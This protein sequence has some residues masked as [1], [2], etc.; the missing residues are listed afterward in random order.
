MIITRM[1]KAPKVFIIILN[2]NGLD[3]VEQCLGG[4]FQISYSN[5]EVVVVDNNSQDGSFELAKSLF[6]KAHF[7][8]NK[9]NIGFAAGN[10]VGIRFALERMADYVFLLNNDAEVEVGILTKLVAAAE[11]R[12][13]IGILSPVIYFPENNKAWFSGGKINWLTMKTVHNKNSLLS[14]PFR[15]GSPESARGGI[16]KTDY[17]TGCAMLVKKEVFRAIGLFDESFFLYYEDADLSVRAKRKGFKLAVVSGAEAYHFE[18]SEQDKKSKTYW[19]VISGI[20]F[21]KKNTPAWLRP[22]ME[23]YLFLRRLKNRL[24]MKNNKGEIA[25]QVQKAYADYY[26]N[27]R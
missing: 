23:I 13:S 14:S 12:K 7:I 9:A 22:W 10:N 16:C 11:K 17:I 19:L 8:K 4:V 27:P 21:F 26:N 24:D 6:P 2:Y 18:K 15:K 5:F 3:T 25:I 20:I 1:N